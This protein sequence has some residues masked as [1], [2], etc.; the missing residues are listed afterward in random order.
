VCI[1][2][3]VPEIS[4]HCPGVPFLLVGNKIDLREDPEMVDRLASRGLRIITKAEGE[5]M[6]SQIG[7]VK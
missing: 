3:W 1:E 6:A 7:A 2:Q 4:H 5:V